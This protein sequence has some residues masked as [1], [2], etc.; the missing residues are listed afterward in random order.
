MGTITCEEYVVNR[1][2]ALEKENDVLK[3]NIQELCRDNERLA[4]ANKELMDDFEDLKAFLRRHTKLKSL[5]SGSQYVS[6]GDLN[7]WSEREDM[8]YL[9]N[10]LELVDEEEEED[11]SEKSD[12]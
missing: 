5:E 3:E 6:I 2:L 4:D 10:V 12:N 8:L 11:G 7:D 1:I 9:V